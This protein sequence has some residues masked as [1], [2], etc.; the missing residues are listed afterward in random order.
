[1]EQ[2]DLPQEKFEL[3]T[4]ELHRFLDQKFSQEGYIHPVITKFSTVWFREFYRL[5]EQ[6]DPYKKIKDESNQKA[7]NVM[8]SL[9][10]DA[11]TVSFEDAL[12]IAVKGN[13]LDYGAVLVLNPRLEVLQ[14][15]FARIKEV[16]FAINDSAQLFQAVQNAKKILFLPD[17]AGE[18]MFDTILLE[19]IKSIN[20]NANITIAAKE[21]PMLNDVTFAELQELGIKK[22]GDLVSTGSD[23]FGLHEE[24]VSQEMKR[25]LKETD[26]VIAKGQAYLEFFT[27]YNLE[28]VFHIARVKYPII[29]IGLQRLE[30][31]QNVVLSSK[32]YAA[33]GK[34]YIFSKEEKSKKIIPRAEIAR[35]AENLRRERKKI[36]TINGSYDI[37]HLGHIKTL[38]EAKKQGDVL[39][40]GLNSDN[41][42]KQYKSKLRPI[43]NQEA[44]AE[45]MAALECVDYVFVFDETNPIAFLDEVKTDVHCN[46][47]EYGEDCIEAEVVK[48]HGGKIY[49]TPH[50]PPHSTSNLIKKIVEVEEKEKA[51][52]ESKIQKKEDEKAEEM[53]QQRQ[54]A[55][56]FSQKIENSNNNE[57][58]SISNNSNTEE[59]SFSSIIEKQ[60]GILFARPAIVHRETYLGNDIIMQNSNISLHGD[61]RGYVPVEWWIMSLT[62]AGNEIVQDHEGMSRVLVKGKEVLLTEL[63][64]KY[65]QEVFGQYKRGWPL[66]KILDIG[67]KKVTPSFSEIAE[68]PPIPVHVHSGEIVEG[69]IQGPGKSEAYFFPPLDITPYNKKLEPQ[70]TRLGVKNGVSKEQFERALEYFGKNDTAYNLCQEYSINPYDGWTIPAGIIHAPGPWVTFEIQLPQDDFNLLSWQLGQQLEGKELLEKKQEL[71]LRGL[72]NERDVMQQ[73]V[74]WENS[75]RDD[76]KEQFYRPSKVIEKGAWGRRMQIFFDQFYGEAIEVSPGQDFVRAKENRPFAG[77]VWSGK[78]MING[79]FLNVGHELQKEFLVTPNREVRIKNTGEDVLRIY[80]VFPIK[81]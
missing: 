55:I 23:C 59:S 13:Q 64:E 67:G 52:N 9:N 45:F 53:I 57:N 75:A 29:N 5:A 31:H 3:L 21:K 47:I 72:Q 16:E 42:I 17:N 18:I 19:K 36:V 62:Q 51:I 70:K 4:R 39:I 2:A 66:T 6:S 78:G 14:E 32:R 40:V 11:N 48:K 54:P 15:E 50:F 41:S 38:Q 24:D 71:Q 79:N 35:L 58:E 65:E 49:L 43:N 63:A 27:E 25:V 61:S 73:A 76:F 46:G 7:K 77:I 60:Q 37:M 10:L 74:D 56:T 69:K 81:R 1:M 33:H 44:R 80:T 68:V 26:I 12:K 30:Q 28:N 34:K 22:Y 20:P 8:E